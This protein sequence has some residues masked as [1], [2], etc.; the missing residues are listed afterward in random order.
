MVHISE[1]SEDKNFAAD[2]SFCLHWTDAVLVGVTHQQKSAANEWVSEC[3]WTAA[4]AN[5]PFY[6]W[7]RSKVRFILSL[8]YVIT[9]VRVK[10]D[11]CKRDLS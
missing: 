11:V 9:P 6:L 1:N 2:Y 3:P 4:R 10:K 5:Q 8:T 7:L